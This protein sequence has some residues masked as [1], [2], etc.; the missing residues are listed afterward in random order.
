[1]NEC[2]KLILLK[3]LL[4]LTLKLNLIRYS[5]G[6]LLFGFGLVMSLTS[7]AQTVFVPDP[8]S[9]NASA[10]ALMSFETGEYIIS[11]NIDERLPPASLTKI[12]TAYVAASEIEQ[13]KI[14]LTDLVPI[15]VAAWKKGGSKMF[16]REGTKVK[17]GDLLKGI[18]IQSGNDA[19]IAVAEYLAGSESSFS[20][21]MNLHAKKLQMNGTHYVNSTGWPDEQQYTTAEDL[22][23]LT[24]ALIANYPEHYKTYREK[25]FS[26]NGISQNNRNSLL[27]RDEDVDGVK[28]GHTDEAGYCLVASAKK[29]GVRLISVVMG[30]NNHRVRNSESYKLLNYGFRFY[31]DTVVTEAYE[32]IAMAPIWEA[33]EK[34]LPLGVLESLKMTLP[35]GYKE[36]LQK[37][38]LLNDQII[39]PVSVGQILGQVTYRFQNETVFESPLVALN[40]VEK[41]GIFTIL[42]HRLYLA[43]LSWF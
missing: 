7:S 21:L 35:K 40:D 23:K 38:V 8:P 33:E 36:G 39:A 34:E 18:I 41:A 37:E 11:H 13:G 30:A 4:N 20:S 9:I 31:E 5:S 1:M 10:Y 24:R 22:L 25:S 19:S 29:D 27:F 12:M 6:A 16:V 14:A 17:L 28:T 42:W 32:V 3:L 2:L 43:V 26:Y 15:S